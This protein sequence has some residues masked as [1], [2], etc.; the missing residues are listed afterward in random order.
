MAKPIQIARLVHI[1]RLLTTHK[2]GL[3]AQ[4]IADYLAD[5]GDEYAFSN[6][7]IR[8]DFDDIYIAFG[9]DITLNAKEKVWAI[10]PDSIANKQSILDHLL[11]VDAHRKAK[12][13]GTLL[14]EVQ[15]E[16]G[17]E[18]LDPILTAISQNVLITF[19]H[20]SFGWETTKAYQVLP[21]A[22]KEY[23]GRWYLIATDNKQPIKL[24]AF[25][26]DRISNLEVTDIQVKRKKID[27]ESFFEHFYGVAIAEG[28]PLQKVVLSFDYE[29]GKYIKS[30]KLHPSQVTLIDNEDE[31]RVQLTLAFPN[32]KAPY[33]LVMKLCS[34]S[35]SVKIIAPQSLADEVANYHKAAYEQY[36]S[37]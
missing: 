29:Q 23:Q 14:L 30:L 33:D 12:N 28:E 37:S 21:Y 25:A 31:L 10:N 8:R 5:E 26:L 2:N 11:L 24:K 17:L 36:Q 18:M 16:K 13:T 22:V 34:F 15:P 20:T 19:T 6:R 27:M 35:C 1:I 7:T 32:G 4:S 9:I 3:S